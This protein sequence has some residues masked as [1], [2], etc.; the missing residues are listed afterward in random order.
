MKIPIPG[1]ACLWLAA[2]ISPVAADTLDDVVAA[3]VLR[4]AVVIDFPPMGFRAADGE[5]QGFDVEYCKDLAG[6]LDVDHRIVPVTFAE[7]LPAIVDGKADVVVGGT[8]ITLERARIVGFSIPYAVFFAQAVV[9]ADGGIETVEDLKGKR[10]G[11][12][13][14]TVQETEFLKI[15]A[16]WGSED[17][18]RSLPS[19]D[20]VFAALADGEIDAG[21]V[22]NTE[23]P[24]LL[25]DHADLKAGP[26]MPWAPDITALAG[27]RTDASWINYLDLFI[28]AQVG[29]GRYQALWA[30][31][32]GGEAPELPASGIDY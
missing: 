16:A 25:A 28:T 30:R 3:G 10:V 20:A 4:C 9:G 7:R 29:S 23:V 18:Y 13:A 12:A 26:R 5:P 31:F 15:A 24:P 8:S 1:L 11:A 2:T 22:T 19:E 32:V 14:S 21:I 17:L 6:S 27:P